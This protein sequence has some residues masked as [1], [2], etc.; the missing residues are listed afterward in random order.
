MHRPLVGA[1]KKLKDSPSDF[2]QRLASLVRP[3]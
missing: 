3:D 1:Y 2:K